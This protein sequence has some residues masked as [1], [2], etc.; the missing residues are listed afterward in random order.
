MNAFVDRPQLPRLRN[1]PRP[2]GCLSGELLA[3]F[4]CLEESQL[5]P[6]VRALRALPRLGC[7]RF[8]VVLSC[9]LIGGGEDTTQE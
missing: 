9:P 7:R 1:C 4:A 6:N 3:V 2:L 8:A 5:F